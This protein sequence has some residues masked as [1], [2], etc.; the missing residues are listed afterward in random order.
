M[1]FGE[2]YFCA[3]DADGNGCSF[4]NSNYMGFGSGVIPKGCGFTLQNR[5]ANFSLEKGHPNELQ[6][7]RRCFHTIIPAMLTREGSLL[8]TFGVMGGFMQPQGH[9]QVVSNMID[10]GMGPQQAL[11]AA[12]ICI[13]SGDEPWEDGE[14]ACEEGI[15]PA[16]LATLRGMGHGVSGV[17]GIQ[18]LTF[19]KGQIIVKNGAVLSGGSDP[20]ADGMAIGCV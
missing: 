19:G 8:A 10:F 9:V 16:T 20:R 18:R 7:G 14:I 11:D 4:I 2:V 1:L 3:V 13:G 17:A 6:G 5:G 12:R 15:T